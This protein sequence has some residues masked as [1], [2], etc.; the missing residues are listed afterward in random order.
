MQKVTW[1][2]QL[3][4]CRPTFVSSNK[5]ESMMKAL[6][7]WSSDVIINDCTRIVAPSTARHLSACYVRSAGQYGAYALKQSALYSLLSPL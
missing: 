3:Q 2:S 5:I 1:I 4:S 6:V 7:V